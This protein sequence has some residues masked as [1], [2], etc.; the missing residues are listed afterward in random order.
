MTETKSPRRPARAPALRLGAG[1]HLDVE[2][3]RRRYEAS[4]EIKKAEL[5]DGIVYMAPPVYDDHSQ[6]NSNGGARHYA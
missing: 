4:P 5:I 6:Q 1:D 2:E 3:F